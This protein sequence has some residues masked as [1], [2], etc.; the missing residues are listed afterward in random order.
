MKTLHI[1]PFLIIILKINCLSKHDHKECFQKNIFFPKTGQTGVTD[2]KVCTNVNNQC[3]FINLTHRYGD[4]QINTYFCGALTKKQ[5]AFLT[6]FTNLYNDDLLSYAN[7][8]GNNY[9]LFKKYGR[10]LNQTTKDMFNC[11]YGPSSFQEYSTYKERNC[12]KF[13]DGECLYV[14]NRTSFRE[15]VRDYQVN[16]SGLYCPKKDVDGK[17]ISYRGTR[18]NDKMVRPLFMDLINY[19]QADEDAYNIINTFTNIDIYTEEDEDDLNTD[20]VIKA[21]YDSNGKVI[22]NCTE[23]PTINFT[24][25][26]PDG[27]QSSRF[28][29]GIFNAL[30]IVAMILVF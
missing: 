5:E 13:K 17:C 29:K 4:H 2:P 1:L 28:L 19:L 23:R 26:C 24:I 8:T 22:K 16:Y 25:V 6:H 21:W 11:Y 27:F 15:F 20:T 30:Y 7:F 3:C 18:A 9:E 14:K 10:N 12:A